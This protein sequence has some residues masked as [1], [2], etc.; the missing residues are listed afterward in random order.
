MELVLGEQGEVAEDSATGSG[1]DPSGIVAGLDH[2]V[3]LSS[4]PEDSLRLY[5]DALG[6]RLALDRS[7]EQRG[8]RLI[9]F[10]VGGTTLEIGARLGSPPQ[11][12]HSDAFGGLAWRVDDAD[13][14]R[15]RLAAEGFDV[16]EVRAG[17]KPGTRV[18]TVRGPTHGVGTLL[19]Q[20]ASSG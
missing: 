3:V 12:E 1:R 15:S 8:V 11:P 2:L 20:A 7:F 9:F 17:H 5:R 10:R 18:C 13:A 19:I 4:S 14:I 6:L 16:S